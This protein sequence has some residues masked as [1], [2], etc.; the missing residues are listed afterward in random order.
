[1]GNVVTGKSLAS[2]DEVFVLLGNERNANRALR[3]GVK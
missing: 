2:D 1:M 3:Q